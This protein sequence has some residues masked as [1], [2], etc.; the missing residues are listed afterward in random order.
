MAP[1]LRKSGT[2]RVL[3]FGQT[4]GPR[5]MEIW[6]H[7]F[8]NQESVWSQIYAN[9]GP[10]AF[11]VVVK[12]M[13]QIYGN[14]EP[15]VILPARVPTQHN[16]PQNNTIHNGDVLLMQGSTQLF[17]KH[18]VPPHHTQANRRIN[19]TFRYIPP[20]NHNCPIHT[21]HK[22]RPVKPPWSSYTC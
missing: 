2:I 1:D 3:G 10:Y 13:V 20:T 22:P 12:R 9:L 6:D 14:L 4:Y 11:S 7:T 16:F 19:V 18:S 15:Y 5:F 17:Y 21:Q 8:Q